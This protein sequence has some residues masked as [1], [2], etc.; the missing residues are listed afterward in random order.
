M[1][2]PDT[3]PM[4]FTALMLAM[5]LYC[6]TENDKLW[7]GIAFLGYCGGVVWLVSKIVLGWFA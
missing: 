4:A 2:L 6:K 3:D 7:A 5:N 1:T